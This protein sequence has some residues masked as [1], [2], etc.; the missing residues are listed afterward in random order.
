MN[1]KIIGNKYQVLKVLFEYENYYAAVCRDISNSDSQ[2]SVILNIYRSKPSILKAA[3]VYTK[4][5]SDICNDFI[6]FFVETSDVISVFKY[7][8]Y[9][10]IDSFLN[11]NDISLKGR[12]ALASSF[13]LEAIRND[14]VPE[15][16]KLN[17]MN[18]RHIVVDN[19]NNVHFNFQTAFDIDEKDAENQLVEY[20]SI[21]LKLILGKRKKLPEIFSNFLDELESGKYN[22]VSE[23][24]SEF[25]SVSEIFN[26][27]EENVGKDVADKAKKAV[28]KSAKKN[29]KKPVA[30]VVLKAAVIIL[31]IGALATGG[32]F[33][34]KYL[35][36]DIPVAPVS[37]DN[38]NVIDNRTQIML[39]PKT[40][41]KNE[42]APEIEPIKPEKNDE[43]IHVVQISDNLY[44][45][46]EK[47]Y[48]NGELYEI[49]RERNNLKSNV[50]Y[51][52]MT[53]II[54][55]QD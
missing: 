31:L 6:D 33:I 5:N 11:E 43:R 20:I 15:L 19:E 13:L 41:A 55:D 48:G 22:M 27:A 18:P 8:D 28:I 38:T 9:T 51:V 54:P 2:Y 53:L 37:D 35:I 24:F 47:Y 1:K 12:I 23:I 29:I 17:V 52:G 10:S 44:D 39:S 30:L 40:P 14:N 21:I 45:I 42:P 50:I 49:I 32:Y 26:K 36:M 7:Y 16:L 34:C 4:I 25:N 3:P 46:A